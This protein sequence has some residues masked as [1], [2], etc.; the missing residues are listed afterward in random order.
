MLKNQSLNN[1]SEA[2]LPALDIPE[3]LNYIA[4]FLTLKCHLNCSYCINDPQQ[5][6]DRKNIFKQEKVSLSPLE[7][8]KGLGRLKLHDDLPV[9]LQGGEPMIYGKGKGVGELLELLPFKFD[10]LTAFP[11]TPERLALAFNGQQEKLK[12][13]AP[14]PSIRVSYHPDQ[15]EKLWHGVGFEELVDRC[16]GMKDFG[17]S[18]SPNKSES[19]IGIYMVDHPENTFTERMRSALKD[20]VSFEEKEFLGEH[21]G[22][23]YGT[24]RYPYSTNLVSSS[25]WNKT[26]SCECRTSELLLDPLGF[27][28]GCHFHLYENWVNGGPAQAFQK[29]ADHEY[30]FSCLSPED[31]GKHPVMPIGHILDPAF[32]LDR[33]GEFRTCHFY[34]RCIGCDTKVKNNRFQS[35]DDEKKPHTSVEIRAIQIDPALEQKFLTEV[36][37]DD[38]AEFKASKP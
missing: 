34:G 26:I 32:S 14:Y 28:W 3:S 11:F 24:Y 16:V 20:K 19:D 35:L 27:A 31:F 10:L 9:T 2:I 30:D 13:K 1:E 18:V 25:T 33:L 17:F 5:G 22:Q 15:M 6:S 7:W 21:E 29:L 12:R 37:R 38:L 4:V 36:S 8:A 23:L